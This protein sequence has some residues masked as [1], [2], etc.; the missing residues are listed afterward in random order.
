[1]CIDMYIH[2]SFILLALARGRT[3]GES[4]SRRSTQLSSSAA[5]NRPNCRWNNVTSQPFG[6]WIRVIEYVIFLIESSI[7]DAMSAPSHWQ[8]DTQQ[9]VAEICDGA[10]NLTHTQFVHRPIHVLA[11]SGWYTTCP[12]YI[13]MKYLVS[14]YQDLCWFTPAFITGHFANVWTTL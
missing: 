5:Q 9:I 12:Q 13:P 11:I 7:S 8:V 10:S 4:W 2:M 14:N 3:T 6:D 1:M